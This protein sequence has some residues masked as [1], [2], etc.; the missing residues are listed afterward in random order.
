MAV[1]KLRKNKPLTASDLSELERMLAES[2]AG[3]TDEIRRA[4]EASRG[5]GLFVR[6]LVGMDREAAKEAIAGFIAG[7]SLS[8]NHIEFINLIVDQLTEH[9]VMEAARLYESP[10]TD[11]TPRGPDGLFQSAEVDELMR[12]LEAVRSTALAA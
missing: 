9:G 1:Q 5:L 6:S 12:V 4:A 8:A 7:K 11:V 3:G 2:G 10:F